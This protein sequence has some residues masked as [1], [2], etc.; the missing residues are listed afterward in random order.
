MAKTYANAITEARQLLQD[1]DTPQ[2]YT[3]VILLAKLNRALQELARLRPDAF[4]D[5][6]DDT[7]GEIVVPEVVVTDPT[8]DSDPDT[9]DATED[10]QVATTEN[11]L[12]PMQ[13]YTP[14]VYFIVASAEILDDEF[15]EDGR[16]SM[17]MAQFKQ[18]IIGL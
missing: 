17:L 5:Q 12:P 16:A 11:F 8:P 7:T 6:F 3:D 1:T 13:F 10:G 15:T 18:S 4:F 9:I 14:V 2:R